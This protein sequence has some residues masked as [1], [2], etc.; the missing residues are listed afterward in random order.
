VYYFLITRY[1]CFFFVSIELSVEKLSDD[2]NA[3]NNFKENESSIK[4]SLIALLASLA[5]LGNGKYKSK[6]RARVP[7]IDI[8]ITE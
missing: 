6:M 5:R 3:L 2:F 7:N 1:E 4:N 8:E